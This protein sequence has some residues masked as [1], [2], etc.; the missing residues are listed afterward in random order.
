M[1][2]QDVEAAGNAV[3]AVVRTPPHTAHTAPPS[4]T[5][6]GFAHGTRQHPHLEGGQAWLG[7]MAGAG[8]CLGGDARAG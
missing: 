8:V 2:A 5:A 4:H 3:G 6:H 7:R 1:G